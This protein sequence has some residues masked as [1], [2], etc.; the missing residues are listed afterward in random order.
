MKVPS[1]II[2]NA[3]QVDLVVTASLEAEEC[4]DA[5]LLTEMEE[6][7]MNEVLATST[8]SK[9]TPKRREANEDT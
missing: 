9:R 4:A 5:D 2:K 3:S 7:P 6:K 1:H 8:K